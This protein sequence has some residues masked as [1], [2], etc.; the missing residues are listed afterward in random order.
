MQAGD[1]ISGEDQFL[2][3]LVAHG[4]LVPSGVAGVYGRGRHFEQI[5]LAFDAL[6]T[7]ETAPD[8]AEFVRF[9]PVLPRHDLETSGYLAS[10]PQLAGSVFGF[11]GDEVAAIALA[12]QAAVHEDWS[13]SQ[14]MTDLVL[15]PAACYPV[16]PWVASAGKLPSGGRLVDVLC[17]CFRHEPSTDPA[18]MQ[19]FRQRENVCIGEAEDV[20]AWHHSWIDRG[21]ALLDSTGLSAKAVEANDAFFGRSGRMLA[22]SQREQ[23][24][25]LELVYPINLG[26]SPTAIMSINY[27]QDHFGSDFGIVTADGRVAHTACFGFGLERI[28]LALLRMHGLELDAWPD[29]IRSRLLV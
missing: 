18:R 29:E 21:L 25:K 3:R 7:R 6:V 1:G 26:A 22:A 12:E 9:P 2:E 17:Y 19:A 15:L 28:T 11:A 5:A 24:L 27:H 13:D 4:L 20:A 14:T 10:F 16:Y 23:G 8:G